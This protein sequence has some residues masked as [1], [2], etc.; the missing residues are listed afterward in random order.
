MSGNS[1][2]HIAS[3]HSDQGIGRAKAESLTSI[4]TI[5]KFEKGQNI[6]TGGLIL[7]RAPAIVQAAT[8]QQSG[9]QRA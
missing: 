4:S 2:S 9:V 3:S 6:K 1:R 5:L 8:N 7:Q